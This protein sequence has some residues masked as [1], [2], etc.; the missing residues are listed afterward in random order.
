VD[1]VLTENCTADGVIDLAGGWFDPADQT[2]DELLTAIRAHMAESNALLLG[3]RTFEAFRGYWPNQTDDT[4][5]ITH[6]LNRVEKYVLSTTLED[7]MWEPTTILRNLDEVRALRN[8]P[9]G[10]DVGGSVS[11]AQQLVAADLVD[12]YRLFVYPVL[13]GGGPGILAT[14]ARVDLDLVGATPFPSG[15]TLLRYARRRDA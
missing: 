5:G 1:I 10:L 2:D 12:E 11:V 14:T 6:N 9:G 3:R 7:P 4:T 15:V 8:Q 13:V